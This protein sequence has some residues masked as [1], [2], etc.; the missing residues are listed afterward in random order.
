MSKILLEQGSEA[1]LKYRL[2]K[3]MATDA[4]IISGSNF[5]STELDLWEQKLLLKPPQQMNPAMERGQVLEPEARKLACEIIGINFEPCVYESKHHSWA[6][7]SL[8]GINDATNTIL[9]IKAPNEK[10]HCEAIEGIIKPYYA[11]QMQW[12]M[13]VCDAP[14][15]YY[16][17]YRPEYTSD[18]FA[19]LEVKAD[20][21]KQEFL[22]EKCR[23]FYKKMCEFDPPVNWILNKK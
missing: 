11:D 9:E 3:I 7:A 21:E 10:S 4:S 22:L 12:Q 19:L 17:S 1:W 13:L 20:F 14:L 15:C 18:I 5:F 16:F 8:D 6:A 2:G 23:I